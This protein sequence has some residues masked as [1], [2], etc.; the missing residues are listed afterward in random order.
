MKREKRGINNDYALTTAK[1][2]RRF[3]E[4]GEVEITVPRDRL[5]GI[6]LF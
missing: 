1:A 3:I 4:Y 5:G 2:N 6:T